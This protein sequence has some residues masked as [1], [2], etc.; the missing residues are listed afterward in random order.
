VVV[1]FREKLGFGVGVV[2]SGR[3][4]FLDSISNGANV[5]SYS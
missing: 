4:R 2:I 3:E 5:I 1:R